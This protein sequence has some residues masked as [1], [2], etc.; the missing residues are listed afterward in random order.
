MLTKY[1]I[2]CHKQ[3]QGTIDITFITV[4]CIIFIDSYQVDFSY[5]F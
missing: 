2:S 5:C 1:R 4:L 3:M